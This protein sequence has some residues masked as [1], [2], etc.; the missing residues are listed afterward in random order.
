MRR[1]AIERH[2]TLSEWRQRN[3]LDEG[4]SPG[5]F[6]KGRTARGCPR[7]CAHCQARR[8]QPTRQGLRSRLTFS[9]WLAAWRQDTLTAGEREAV[10]G[11]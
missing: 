11:E 7:R 10:R 4:L 3:E 6:R 5:C 8:Q 9:E 1:A 2:R